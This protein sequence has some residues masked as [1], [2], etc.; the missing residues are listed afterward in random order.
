MTDEVGGKADAPCRLWKLPGELRNRI[1]RYVL[2]KPE[3]AAGNDRIIVDATGYDRPGV[4]ST[5]K[6]IRKETLKIFYSENAFHIEVIN[7]NSST[8]L[9]WES[10]LKPM[11]MQERGH[12]FVSVHLEDEVGWWANLLLWL[13]RFHERKVRTRALAP[14]QVLKVFNSKDAGTH[15]MGAM[16]MTVDEFRDQP[17]Q[18]IEKHIQNF[19][20]ALIAVQEP[21]SKD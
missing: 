14:E 4:V 8:L 12:L 17:W 5:C 20:P 6:Q 11:R 10:H 2:L 7:Y 13:Q 3:D 15:L 16:F 9:R 18:R 19:R 21:W 1:Y